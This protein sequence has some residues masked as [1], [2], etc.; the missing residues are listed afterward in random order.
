[1]YA[2]PRVEFTSSKLSTPLG[3][4]DTKA[5]QEELVELMKSMGAESLDKKTKE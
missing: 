4:N 3:V 5:A 1:M 2:D